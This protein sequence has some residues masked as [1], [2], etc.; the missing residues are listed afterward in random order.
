MYTK[1]NT[2]PGSLPR[3]A[4][5]VDYVE[6]MRKYGETPNHNGNGQAA[7]GGNGNATDEEDLCQDPIARQ[8]ELYRRSIGAAEDQDFTHGSVDPVGVLE[9]GLRRTLLDMRRAS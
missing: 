2:T 9:I 3:N 8:I 5:F 1:C 6:A 7:A 4:G